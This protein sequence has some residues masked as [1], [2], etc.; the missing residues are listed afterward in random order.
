M[1]KDKGEVVLGVLIICFVSL[2]VVGY[3]IDEYACRNY[4][5]MTMMETDYHPFGGGCYVKTK[6][7]WFIREQLRDV[8]MSK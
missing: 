2:M 7:G 8:D 5:K 6:N 4:G 3:L 1:R